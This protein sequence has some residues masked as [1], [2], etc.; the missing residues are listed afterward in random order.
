MIPNLIMKS[1]LITKMEEE[2]KL[3]D[4]QHGQYLKSLNKEKSVLE[5]LKEKIIAIQK[6]ANVHLFQRMEKLN[7]L[8]TE[9]SELLKRSPQI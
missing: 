4:E 9:L 1:P 8:K 5:D 6:N 3:L 2:M 7:L